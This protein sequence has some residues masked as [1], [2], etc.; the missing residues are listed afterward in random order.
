MEKLWKSLG[1]RIDLIV[2]L[3]CLLI[4]Y[5]VWNIGIKN[6]KTELQT[7]EN[8][9]HEVVT[10]LSREA[11]D[12]FNFVD[13]VSGLYSTSSEVTS[14]DLSTYMMS[15]AE[16]TLHGE[17]LRISFVARV[18]NKDMGAYE[19]I[20][21]KDGQPNYKA[22]IVSGYPD[23]YVVTQTVNKKGKIFPVSGLNLLTDQDRTKLVEDIIATHESAMVAV[24]NI[25]YMS[26]YN[27]PGIIF[28]DPVIKNGEL[29]GFVTAVVSRDNLS[30][31]VDN[32]LGEDYGWEWYQND[33]KIGGSD[34]EIGNHLSL[35]KEIPIAPSVSWKIIIHAPRHPIM[36]WN[37]ILGSGVLLS[38]LIYVVVYS[39]SSANAR[40]LEMAKQMT[41]DMQKYKLALDSASNHIVITDAEGIVLYAN[42]AAQKLTGFDKSEI[43][44]KTPALWGGQMGQDFYVNFWKVIKTDKKVFSGIFAN[45]RKNG[46][47]YSAEATVSPIL[48]DNEELVGFVGVEIDVTDEYKSIKEKEDNLA[49]L[50]K[51]N[52]LMLGREMKMVELKKLLV[53]TQDELSKL[54]SKGVV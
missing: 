8:K 52:Q 36:L 50:A 5:L 20:V 41:L 45:K 25:N 33:V 13:G 54:K 28:A 26:G 19:A 51:F 39:L 7:L 6:D 32:I 17:V 38:F 53:A 23:Q 14:Q 40:G 4:T 47:L 35:T 37:I 9:N 21:R 15:T 49:K 16:N 22:Q 44:G 46:E 34:M 2:L 27:G 29:I 48:L 3:S 1:E 24:P 43:L 12:I 31:Q 42:N 18:P 30:A 10:N 11:E